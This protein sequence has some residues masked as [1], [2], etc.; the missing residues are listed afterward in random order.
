MLKFKKDES[1]VYFLRTSLCEPE[2]ELVWTAYNCIRNIESSF[3][4]L[5]SDLDL[6]PIFHKT[7]EASEAH[8]HLGLLAYWVVNTIRHKL[9]QHGIH[10]SWKEIVRTMNTQKVVTTTAMNDKE[11]C[12]SIRRCSEPTEKVKLIYDA[13]GYKYA[14]FIRKKSVVPKTNFK[15]SNKTINEIDTG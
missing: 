2:E 1:G 11:Q 13:L 15:K 12:I 3:R 6:R 10:S 5:K 7:D 9:K 4:C 8:L 14:P